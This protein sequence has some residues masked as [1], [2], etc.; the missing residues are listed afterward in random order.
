MQNDIKNYLKI[1]ARNFG[2]LESCAPG[3]ELAVNSCIKSLAGKGKIIWCGNGGSAADAQHMAAELMGRYKEER[4]PLPSIAL[5][6]DTSAL[7]AIGNDYGMEYVFSRQLRGI[8]NRGDVLIAISTSG[9][10]KNV[11][12]AIDACKDMEITTI[13]LTGQSGGAMKDICDIWIG[14]PSSETNHI[15]EMHLAVEHFICGAVEQ[16]FKDSGRPQ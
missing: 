14:V 1:V 8:G 11:L 12:K 9:N 7:T 2:A 6:T 13:G 5:T 3:I 16:A 15:Q 4:D 10:S